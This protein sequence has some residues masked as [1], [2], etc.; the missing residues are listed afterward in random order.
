MFH[1]FA[2]LMHPRH[3]VAMDMGILFGAPFSL[4]PDRAWATAFDRLPLPSVVT[5]KIYFPQAPEEAACFLIAV[6]FTATQMLTLPRSR[7][8]AKLEHAIDKAREANTVVFRVLGKP[9][10]T[11]L[12][13]SGL[14]L[15]DALRTC[16]GNFPCIAAGAGAH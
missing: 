8:Q 1:K 12:I 16:H 6:P 9:H 15:A 13:R 2:F 14:T 3:T 7:V 10:F 11:P 4:V 5:G